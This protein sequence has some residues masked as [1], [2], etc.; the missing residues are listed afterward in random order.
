[1]PGWICNKCTAKTEAGAA[2]GKKMRAA[3]PWMGFG[4]PDVRIGNVAFL[5]ETE[6]QQS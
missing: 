6:T 5:P 4:G 1:M 3:V 2:S